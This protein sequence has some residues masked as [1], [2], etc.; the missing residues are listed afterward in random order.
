MLIEIYKR[1]GA[2][3]VGLSK[4]GRGS[5]SFRHLFLILRASLL[6]M[7]YRDCSAVDEV[8]LKSRIYKRFCNWGSLSVVYYSS[9]MLGECW[10]LIPPNDFGALCGEFN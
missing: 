4:L 10:S 3:K 2:R 7:L 1:I 9:F 5:W 8:L 6:S